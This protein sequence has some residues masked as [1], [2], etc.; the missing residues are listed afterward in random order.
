MTGF[1]LNFKADCYKIGNLFKINKTKKGVSVSVG[2]KNLKLTVNDKKKVTFGLPGTGISY[3]TT[4]GG[5][6]KT[7]GKTSAKKPAAKK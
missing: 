7:S 4:L 6:K 1:C 5:G 2:N 3:D